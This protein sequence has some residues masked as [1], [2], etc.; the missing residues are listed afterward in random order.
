MSRESKGETPSPDVG[1]KHLLSSSSGAL[2]S[3]KS[4]RDNPLSLVGSSVRL[5]LASM[6][7]ES[8][9]RGIRIGIGL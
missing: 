1:T 9:S 5:G 2:P 8:Q 7:T 4:R 3:S 6:V